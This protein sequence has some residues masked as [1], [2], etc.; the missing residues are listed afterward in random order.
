M[1]AFAA[2]LR[3]LRVSAQLF[4]ARPPPLTRHNPLQYATSR[5]SAS[6]SALGPCATRT[7]VQ[8]PPQNLCD[9]VGHITVRRSIT[10]DV[11]PLTP[12][13]TLRCH[14]H[15]RRPR[16][17]RSLCRSS[18]IRRT[19]S[20]HNAQTRQPRRV[21]L[22]SLVRWN[23]QRHHASRNRCSGRRGG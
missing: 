4:V 12:P 14:R 1:V 21:L 10:T 18:S 23:R 22:Q 20:P 11:L 3:D 15:W 17:L 5:S 9:R 13:Q 19:N 7:V 16:R 2:N 8:S 6:A